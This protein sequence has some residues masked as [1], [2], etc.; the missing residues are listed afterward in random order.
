MPMKSPRSASRRRGTVYTAVAV[1]AVVVF[2]VLYRG[3]KHWLGSLLIFGPLLAATGLALY[4]DF[5][6]RRLRSWREA[7]TTAAITPGASA[8]VPWW[9]GVLSVVL[10]FIVMI[11]PVAIILQLPPHWR[12][13]GQI[14]GAI[15]MFSFI[16]IFARLLGR[17]HAKRQRRNE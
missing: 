13:I 15:I 17:F 5:G 16:V 6:Q 10:A 9:M 4:L 2:E 1:V 11:I 7:I 8:P 12:V 14:V 3:Q